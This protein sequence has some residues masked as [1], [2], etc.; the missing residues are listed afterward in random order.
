MIKKICLVCFSIFLSIDLIKAD[1][2]YLG[3]DVLHRA[4]NIRLVAL[5]GPEHGIYGNE[6]ANVPIDD[7]IDPRTGLPRLLT[8]R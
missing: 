7:K 4:K 2:I 1:P 8:L 3:I 6:K 5:F